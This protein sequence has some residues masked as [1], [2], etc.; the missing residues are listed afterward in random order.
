MSPAEKKNMV[1][2]DHPQLSITQQC[3]LVKLS[4][5]SFYYAPV[6]ID[7]AT[8]ELMKAIDRVITKYPFFGSRQIAAFLHPKERLLATIV[9]AD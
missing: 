7:A 3:R 4:R 6:G 1:R 9:Y 5:S 8:L 2:L